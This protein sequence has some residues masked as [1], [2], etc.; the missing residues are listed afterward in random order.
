MPFFQFFSVI[1]TNISTMNQ[2]DELKAVLIHTIVLQLQILNPEKYKLGIGRQDKILLEILSTDELEGIIQ[3]YENQ[4][5]AMIL[6]R[7]TKLIG[8]RLQPDHYCHN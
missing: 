7:K 8:E 5:N 1:L 2:K 3:I 6:A 4:I